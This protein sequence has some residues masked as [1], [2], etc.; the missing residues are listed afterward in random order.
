MQLKS[1]LTSFSRS[2]MGKHSKPSMVISR[3]WDINE[4]LLEWEFLRNNTGYFRQ[5]SL[6]QGCLTN[7]PI[8]ELY[9]IL[10]KCYIDADNWEYK[11]PL[12]TN[13]WW[14]NCKQVNLMQQFT[15]C[16]VIYYGSYATLI[17]RP[18]C[19]ASTYPYQSDLYACT[20]DSV[21]G[22]FKALSCFSPSNPFLL[23]ICPIISS[24]NLPSM[25]LQLVPIWLFITLSE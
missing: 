11:K 21:A 10:C 22:R 18:R 20:Q 17:A 6:H 7:E 16:E 3:R 1:S 4:R 23:H 8:I 9:K 24:L 2:I 19:V 15:H 13:R 14:N 25:S 12:K 5:W